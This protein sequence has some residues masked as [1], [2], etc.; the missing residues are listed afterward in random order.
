VFSI[1]CFDRFFSRLDAPTDLNDAAILDG[2]GTI[3]D[4]S[5]LF[6]HRD[7]QTIFYEQIN[8]IPTPS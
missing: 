4:D 8:Q 2:N 6:I 1:N 7:Y 5:A 3:G